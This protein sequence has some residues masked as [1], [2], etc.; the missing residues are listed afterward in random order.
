MQRMQY[1]YLSNLTWLSKNINKYLVLRCC[2]CKNN[3]LNIN[4][5][6]RGKNKV[7]SLIFVAIIPFFLTPSFWH[8]LLILLEHLIAKCANC[9]KHNLINFVGGCERVFLRKEPPFTLTRGVLIIIWVFFQISTPAD[10]KNKHVRKRTWDTK[11]N[12]KIHKRKRRRKSFSLSNTQ[13][14]TA[15]LISLEIWE[16]KKKLFFLFCL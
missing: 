6:K 13:S 10:D 11:N 7:F 9:R 16:R 1:Q 3:Q 2:F 8:I 14:V 12:I 4:S 5:F 15:F